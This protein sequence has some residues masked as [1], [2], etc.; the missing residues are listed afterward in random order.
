MLCLRLAF[1]LRPG[2]RVKPGAE[3]LAA[4]GPQL[5]APAQADSDPPLRRGC[6][7]VEDVGANG[8]EDVGPETAILPLLKQHLG[9]FRERRAGDGPAVRETED[10]PGK[11]E[12]TSS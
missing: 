6:G 2:T 8:G 3:R 7:D 5:A 11:V 12:V 1:F 4:L 9:F 10:L